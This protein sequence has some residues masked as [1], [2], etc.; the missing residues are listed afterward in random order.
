MSSKYNKEEII[1]MLKAKTL[2]LG[3]PPLIRE[4][5][6]N[7]EQYKYI[8]GSYRNALKLAGIE[9]DVDNKK[10][11]YKRSNE[12][13]LQFIRDKSEELGRTPTSYDLNP[14]LYQNIVYRFGTWNN[15]LDEAGLEQN[16]K[17]YTDEELLQK[18]V[19]YRFENGKYPVSTVIENFSTIIYRFGAWNKALEL[20]D[21]MFQEQFKEQFK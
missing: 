11:K 21:K 19:D 12:E 18:I 7:K 1:K 4:T 17:R 2:E 5:T 6:F 10:G 3:R 20:A 8:F 9:V 13:L 15:A 16:K 14:S